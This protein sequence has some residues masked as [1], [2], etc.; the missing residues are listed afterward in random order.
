MFDLHQPETPERLFLSERLDLWVTRSHF[1]GVLA[2]LARGPRNLC[3]LPLNQVRAFALHCLLQR[4]L[5]P[6]FVLGARG[7]WEGVRRIKEQFQ[8]QTIYSRT[9]DRLSF[10]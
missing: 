5:S 8:V 2:C 6:I 9:L 3:G 7:G 1:W 10:L 4:S